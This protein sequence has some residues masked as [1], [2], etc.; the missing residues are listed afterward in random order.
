VM[1]ACAEN[2]IP[3]ILLDRPNPNGN[4]VDGPVLQIEFSSFVGM[5]PIPVVYGLTMGELAGMIN[6][7]G[8]LHGGVRCDLTVIPNVNYTHSSEYALPVKPSPNLPNQHSI[9]IYPST[10]FFEGTVISEGR[11]TLFPFEVYGHPDLEG[12]FSFTPESIAGMSMSPKLKGEQCFGTDLRNFEPHDGWNS[13]ELKW[14]LNA[15]NIFP[16]KDK[17]FLPYFEKLAGTDLL[18]KQIV[19]GLSEAEIRESW[20]PDIDA[21]MLMRSK[22][23]RYPE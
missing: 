6:G 14:L 11:G 16:E 21:Y 12:D 3:L 5:H 4:Y 10:C 1:E 2:N 23:L 13:I 15:Y 18:R 7:E 8:W 19:S 17:F 22:Y 20:K 9:R